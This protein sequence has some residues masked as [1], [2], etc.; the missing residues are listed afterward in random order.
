V[1]DTPRDIK[2][3]KVTGVKTIGVASGHSSR[4]ELEKAWAD[5]VLDGLKDTRWVLELV[6]G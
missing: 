4:E 2:A 1:G 6:M 3:G 5:F